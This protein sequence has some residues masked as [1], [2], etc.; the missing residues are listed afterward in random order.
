MRQVGEYF[1][2]D[3]TRDVSVCFWPTSNQRSE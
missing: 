1:I 3:S 2:R